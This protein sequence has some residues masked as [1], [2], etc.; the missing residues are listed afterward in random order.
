MSRCAIGFIGIGSIGQRM[1]RNAHVHERVRPVVV[2]DPDREKLQTALAGFP[3]VQAASSAQEVIGH[4]Q[5]DLV[6]VASPPRTHAEHAHAAL[7]A[8][9]P[10]LCEKP[11]GV[12][13]DVSR[14]LV[15]HAG[16]SGVPNAV[17]FVHASGAGPVLATAVRDGAL[18]DVRCAELRIHARQWAERR[19]SEA[20]WLR[21]SDQ[22]GLV[23]EVFSHY[24]F[25]S[26][27]LFGPPRV[28]Y[29]HR[30]APGPEGSAEA[31]V[32]AHLVCGDVPVYLFGNTEGEGADMAEYVVWGER[33][34]RC[35]AD[36][37]QLRSNE[38][39]EWQD[40]SPD[41]ED[42][43]PR[44]FRAQLDNIADWASGRPHTMPDFAE[45]FSVQRAIE[46][47]TSH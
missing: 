43:A 2:W 4:G 24:V 5:V 30:H 37:Y 47:M 9:K 33:S 13:E 26:Q 29:C 11:L 15:A 27:R 39:S 31:Q 45:A 36:L 35:I 34:S 18:G 42:P 23:R 20:P 12:E 7:D 3:D 19:Y 28:V 46:E 32:Q 40:V 14:E 16:R 21:M 8:A 38:G 10:V 41:A 22:G 1:L 44:W 17:N 6:Y 25:L